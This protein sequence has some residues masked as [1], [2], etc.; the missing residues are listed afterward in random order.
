MIRE[1]KALLDNSIDF[2][3]PVLTRAFARMQQ[4][5]LDDRIRALAM[6]NDLIEIALQRIRNLADLDAQ[7]S[8]R[9]SLRRAPDAIRQ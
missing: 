1:I 4:H 6:L 7:L 8:C 5:V 2:D 9:G 3:R